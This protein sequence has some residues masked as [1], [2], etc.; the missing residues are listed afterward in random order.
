MSR[1]VPGLDKVAWQS[2]KRFNDRLGMG[3]GESGPPG[4]ALT[5]AVGEALPKR[6]RPL[7][8]RIEERT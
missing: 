1:F 2:E 7:G 5:G 3:F 8:R 4:V 6:E